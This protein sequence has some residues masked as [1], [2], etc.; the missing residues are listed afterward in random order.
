M[1]SVNGLL[2]KLIVGLHALWVVFALW[3]F[4]WTV[5]AFL[6]H[7]RFFD[8]FWFR[9]LHLVGISIVAALSFTGLYCPLT[10]IETY[11]RI[12]N[13]TAYDGGFILHYAQRWLGLAIDSSFTRAC[14]LLILITA[15]VVYFIRPPQRVR[16]RLG[17]FFRLRDTK[18]GLSKET[19]RR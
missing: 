18:T 12:K 6:I 16:G 2:I 19:L 15:G 3:G 9:T 4:F 11:L 17:R 10:I 1:L 8:F 14:T 5:A 13:A 7:R